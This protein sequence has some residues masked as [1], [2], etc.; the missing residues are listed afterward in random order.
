[1]IPEFEWKYISKNIDIKNMSVML[2]SKEMIGKQCQL[3]IWNRMLAIKV[4]ENLDKNAPTI[5]A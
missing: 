4:R 1:L 2:L 3:E 5:L